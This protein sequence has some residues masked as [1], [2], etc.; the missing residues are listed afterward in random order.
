MEALEIQA[1][2][3]EERHDLIPDLA[4]AFGHCGGWILDR[5]TLSPSNVEFL[6]EFQL[7]LVLDLY[8]AIVATGV[9]LTRSG[10]EVL[11]ELCIRRKHSTLTAESGQIITIRLEIRF[12]DD[13]TMQSVLAS[14]CGLA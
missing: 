6:I 9:E 7:R 5:K 4:A 1:F 13:L 14:G 2:T 3:Y 8:G 12:L 10:H 11:T